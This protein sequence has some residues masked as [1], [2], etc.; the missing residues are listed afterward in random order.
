MAAACRSASRSK[1]VLVLIAILLLR[2][3]GLRQREF[4]DS[5]D[6]SLF[7]SAHLWARGDDRRYLRTRGTPGSVS[8]VVRLVDEPPV[9]L[10]D[11]DDEATARVEYA[12][13]LADAKAY[14]LWAPWL[15]VHACQLEISANDGS[16]EPRGVAR[17]VSE[18]VVP[19]VVREPPVW[20]IVNAD[21][22]LHF[23]VIVKPLVREVA[24]ILA[25]SL[26]IRATLVALVESRK[27]R[28]ARG[29]CPSC[30]YSREGLEATAPCPECG[31]TG[32]RAG[33]SLAT[34]SF[35]STTAAD[36]ASSPRRESELP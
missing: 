33:A 9:R 22:I 10:A 13:E 6:R 24:A 4:R 23:R 27:R 34:G 36:L 26:L 32:S 35:T 14:G 30:G 8:G 15:E 11:R 19:N 5:T 1:L 20:T 21:S 7:Q 17:Y 28:R 31:A 25:L 18:K 29:A 3:A 2:D 16:V 12:F